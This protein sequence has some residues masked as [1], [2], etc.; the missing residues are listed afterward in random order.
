MEDATRAR[1]DAVKRLHDAAN[2]PTYSSPRVRRADVQAAVHLVDDL[3][4]AQAQAQFQA[5]ANADTANLNWQRIEALQA[6][7]DALLAER[8]H[9]VANLVD[10]ERE[11]RA[12]QDRAAP[13]LAAL[14]AWERTKT[15]RDRADWDLVGAVAAWRVAREG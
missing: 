12:A 9:A 8:D 7:L 2:D 15:R 13:V 11:H 14:W 1:L 3:L 10:Q 5:Q 4:A 6:E